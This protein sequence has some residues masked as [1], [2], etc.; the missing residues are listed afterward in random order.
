MVSPYLP[1]RVS[2]QASARGVNRRGY[3]RVIRGGPAVAPAVRASKTRMRN[4][5]RSWSDRRPTGRNVL[6]AIERSPKFCPRCSR[7]K[8]RAMH[9]A[10][11]VS[12]HAPARTH[13][14]DRDQ[15]TAWLTIPVLEPAP[16]GPAERF[17]AAVG[18]NRHPVI[19][20]FAAL[21]AGFARLLFSIAAGLLLTHVLAHASGVGSLQ[22]DTSTGAAAPHTRHRHGPRTSLIGVDH[23]RQV[24]CCRIIVGDRRWSCAP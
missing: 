13:G 7:G 8:P 24:S 9:I 10:T 3:R 20:F 11:H 6:W 23:G 1:C 15:L 2:C 18:R 5:I 22:V 17:A 12:T 21:V 16:G 14:R 4:G 19:V